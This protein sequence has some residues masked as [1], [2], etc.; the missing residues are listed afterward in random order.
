MDNGE[1]AHEA[2]RTSN[3]GDHYAEILRDMRPAAQLVSGAT[4]R[5]FASG[6][7][8]A[9]LDAIL[10]ELPSAR[11]LLDVNLKHEL[12]DRGIEARIEA[13]E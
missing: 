5:T 1:E 12:L 4:A 2:F 13:M 11:R 10:R 7:S 9:H 8:V 3:P 6:L